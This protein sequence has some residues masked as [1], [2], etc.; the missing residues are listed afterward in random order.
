M[1]PEAQLPN[2]CSY[3]G[4]TQSYLCCG[5]DAG[6]EEEYLISKVVI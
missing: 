5:D 2:N 6:D 3:Q 1:D 4:K